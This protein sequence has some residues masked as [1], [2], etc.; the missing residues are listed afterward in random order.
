MGEGAPEAKSAIF[1][2][3]RKT[4]CTLRLNR[5][6]AGDPDWPPES[7]ACDIRQDGPGESSWSSS[8][9]GSVLRLLFAGVAG[10]AACL[11]ACL[12]A[13]QVQV[14][15]QVPVLARGAALGGAC[16]L[17]GVAFSLAVLHTDVWP[18]PFRAAH[19]ERCWAPSSSVDG[20]G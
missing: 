9:L 19:N 6:P 16:F 20:T 14:P 15:E 17:L 10:L 11:A 2:K 8:W 7:I 13:L 3:L 12:C 18:W 1:V 4:H 5:V